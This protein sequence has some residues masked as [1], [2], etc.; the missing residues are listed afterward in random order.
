ME[1]VKKEKCQ[2]SIWRRR[3]LHPDVN[4]ALIGGHMNSHK[5]KLQKLD[6]VA[7]ER[8]HCLPSGLDTKQF[9]R[10]KMQE[11][12]LILETFGHLREKRI[13]VE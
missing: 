7:Q 12:D 3:V 2:D 8:N 10:C 4:T 9:L 5:R 1:N 13:I 11:P 6:Q